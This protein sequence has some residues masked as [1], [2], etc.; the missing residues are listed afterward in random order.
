M[1]IL[2]HSFSEDLQTGASTWQFAPGNIG[3]FTL[4]VHLNCPDARIFTFEPAPPLFAL[5]QENI[6]RH[7]VAA[8][9]YPCALSRQSGTAELTYYPQS[10]GMSSLYPDETEERAVLQTIMDNQIRRG[11]VEL[12]PLLAHADDYFAERFRQ[13]RYSCP[14]KTISEV[15]A[16]TAVTHIDLL[17]ID[18]QKSE[19]DVL[20]GIQEQDWPKIEQIIIKAHHIQGQLRTIKQ[21]LAAKGYQ[22]VVDQDAL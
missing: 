16:E 8:Q 7:G 5:L 10:S 11:E 20:L 21:L 12:K 9:L 3:L 18:V 4:F 17:K 15:M 6:R 1:V 19:H 14:V 2:C 13:E 22:V